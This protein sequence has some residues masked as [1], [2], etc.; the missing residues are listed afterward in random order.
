MLRSPRFVVIFVTAYLVVYTML[1]HAGASF[2]ILG[3]MFLL[4]PVLVIWMVYTVLKYGKFEGKELKEGEEW[5]YSDRS[6]E[7]LGVF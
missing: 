6:K 7:T 3:T 1:F 2:N 4:S 5:G